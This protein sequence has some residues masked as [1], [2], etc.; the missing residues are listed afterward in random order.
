M[1][2]KEGKIKIYGYGE[3]EVLLIEQYLTDLRN[4][5]NSLIVFESAIDNLERIYHHDFPFLPYPIVPLYWLPLK[6]RRVVRYARVW[7]PTM[8]E[9]SSLVPYSEQLILS[10]VK[11]TS[12]G[13]WEFLGKINPLEVIRQYLNDRHERRKDREYRESAEK[14]RLRL[15]NLKLENEVI[16]ERIQIAKELGATDRD[17]APLLNEL[18]NK[19]LLRLDQYQDKGIIEHV[20]R[21]EK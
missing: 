13:F 21:D 9:I 1:I 3:I 18:V 7:P 14:R 5:Y 4:A 16:R 17:L 11:L 2:Q 8:E 12:P 20:E 15:E 19:P 6:P 10:A